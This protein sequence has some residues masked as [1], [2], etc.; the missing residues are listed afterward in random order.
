MHI[1]DGSFL[2]PRLVYTQIGD[3]TGGMLANVP[4][5]KVILAKLRLSNKSRFENE[6]SSETNE[7]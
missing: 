3:S 6:K 1:V 7:S 5:T 4:L 2:N